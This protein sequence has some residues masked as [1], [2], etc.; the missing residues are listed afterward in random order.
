V[1][2]S[3][4]RISGS[5]AVEPR[6][7]PLARLANFCPAAALEG[8]G[9]GADDDVDTADR[10]RG[11]VAEGVV[12]VVGLKPQR[13][14]VRLHHLLGQRAGGRVIRKGGAAGGARLRKSPTRPH[15]AETQKESRPPADGRLLTTSMD[16]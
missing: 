10:D 1:P 14:G 2:A 7:L 6:W 5:P 12:G 15:R 8:G 13:R 11:L 4:V 16:S 9:R 3:M